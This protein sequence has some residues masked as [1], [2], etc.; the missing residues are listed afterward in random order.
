LE[1]AL[2]R[3]LAAC[4]G[5]SATRAAVPDI[6]RAKALA[7][8]ARDTVKRAQGDEDRRLYETDQVVQSACDDVARQSR[9]DLVEDAIATPDTGLLWRLPGGVPVFAFTI[10]QGVRSIPVAT[11]EES[12]SP[13]DLRPVGELDLP[14]DGTQSELS[15]SVTAA[16]SRLNGVP[17]AAVVMFSDGRE[18]TGSAGTV[19]SVGGSAGSDVPVF[20]VLSGPLAGPLCDIAVTRLTVPAAPYVG[21]TIHVHAV[22]TQV[23]ATGRPVEVRLDVDGEATQYRRLT[24]G[25]ASTDLDFQVKLDHAG[26]TR[27]SVSAPAFGDEATADNNRAVAWYQGAIGAIERGDAFVDG[28]LG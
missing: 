13:S 22:L 12:D 4:Q 9:L 19:A 18:V 21:Q 1:A 5:L 8:T 27:V 11:G 23:G 25:E 16:L 20:T 26:V 24:L 14:A 7:Q 15:G 10:G 6:G 17:V 2:S 28:E 3:L